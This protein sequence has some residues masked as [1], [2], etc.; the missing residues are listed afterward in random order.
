MPSTEEP[1]EGVDV[2]PGLAPVFTVGDDVYGK[3]SPDE[4]E[5]VLAKYQ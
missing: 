2:T 3:L 5:A 4:A 1:V